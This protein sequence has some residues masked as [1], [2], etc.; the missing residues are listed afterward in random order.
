[1]LRM[2]LKEK[3]KEMKRLHSPDVCEVKQTANNDWN[4]AAVEKREIGQEWKCSLDF[5]K[6]A[7]WC[8]VINVRQWLAISELA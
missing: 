6:L 1:M 8:P 4:N 3:K 2:K 7:K 5:W